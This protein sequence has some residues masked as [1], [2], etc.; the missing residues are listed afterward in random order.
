MQKLLTFFSKN[1]YVYAVFNDKSFNNMLTNDI[2]SSDNWVLVIMSQR[3]TAYLFY[4][5]HTPKKPFLME[6]F[7]NFQSKS[8][9]GQEEKNLSRSKDMSKVCGIM[10]CALNKPSFCKDITLT[11]NL[12][13]LNSSRHHVKILFLTFT[14]LWANL[15]DDKFMICFL[16]F[17][18]NRT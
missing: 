4:C 14:T 1:I 16:F 7:I 10:S 11:V 6:Q 3:L 18:D 13:D 12:W 8:K 2:V 17:P 5:F 9:V 15:A